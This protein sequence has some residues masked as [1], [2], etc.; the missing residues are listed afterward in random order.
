[1]T[2][3]RAPAGRMLVLADPVLGA[4]DGL[5]ASERNATLLRGVRLGA[6]PHARDESRAIAQYVTGP[7]VLLGAHASEHEVKA[8]DLRTYD[9]LHL[10]AHAVADEAHPERSAVLLAAGAPA[11]DGLLQ[12][13]EIAALDIAGT[14]VVLSACQTA[15]GAVL[16][17][18]GTLSLAR[19]FFEGGAHAV[20]GTRWPLRDADAAVLFDTFYRRL[21]KGETLSAALKAARDEAR[22][23]GRPPAAWAALVLLGNGDIRPFAGRRTHT[24]HQRGLGVPVTAALALSMLLAAGI[25]LMRR[26][27]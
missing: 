10:A 21:A 22:A 18:E 4:R 23:A 3:R 2:P 6:L 26:R 15:A 14:V 8:R 24:T 27:A 12:A 20:I 5:V 9:V 7:D 11:E 13:R 1:V 17:G 25:A 16:S 19:A